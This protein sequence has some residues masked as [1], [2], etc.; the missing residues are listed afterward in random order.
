[1]NLSQVIYRC[2]N[3]L[4]PRLTSKVDGIQPDEL[5]PLETDK[6]KMLM[7]VLLNTL[8]ARWLSPISL[9]EYQLDSSTGADDTTASPVQEE[10]TDTVSA[11]EYGRLKDEL[12]KTKRNG[13]DA[14]LENRKLHQKIESYE[15]GLNLLRTELHD[16]RTIAFQQQNSIEETRVDAQIFFPQ[17][18][19]KPI[20]SFGGHVSRLNRIR[21][22]LA[23]VRFISPDTQPNEDL[24]RN[25]NEVWIQPN[26]LSHADF[27][28]IIN[29]V[30]SQH[31]P[32]RYFSYSSAEKCAEQ[33]VI[34]LKSCH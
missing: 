6:E 16:L 26:C 11:E 23:N 5:L 9:D 15:T 20:I 32:V 17:L 34:S 1:M 18:V 28:K 33:L 22:L 19:T 8:N 30:R 27:Y 25:A 29:V 31:I 7:S 12:R 13:Y 3:T 10:S 4:L 24:L 2:T 14:S 21:T